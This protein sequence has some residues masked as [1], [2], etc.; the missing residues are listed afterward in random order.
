V[1]PPHEADG[2]RLLASLSAHGWLGRPLLALVSGDGHQALTGSHRLAAAR[3]LEMRVP[4][5][6]IEADDLDD[7]TYEKIERRLDDDDLLEILDT[8]GLEEAVELLRQE[9]EK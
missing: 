2:D 6:V 9:E 8:A 3:A 5:L 4:L 7:E 1:V